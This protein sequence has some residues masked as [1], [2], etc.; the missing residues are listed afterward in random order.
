MLSLN[1]SSLCFCLPP[2]FLR[3]IR[4]YDVDDLAV[5]VVTKYMKRA[6]GRFA[7]DKRSQEK[8]SLL[9]IIGF[10]QSPGLYHAKNVVLAEPFFD[11]MLH[12]VDSNSIPFSIGKASDAA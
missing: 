3:N 8:A 1:S 7:R 11:H 6:D 10:Q 5:G 4:R 12:G 9:F 2:W